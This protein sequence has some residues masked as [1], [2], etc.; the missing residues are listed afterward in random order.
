VKKKLIRKY[1]AWTLSHKKSLLFFF[2][3]FF[4]FF[5]YNLRSISINTD[6]SSLLPNKFSSVSRVKKLSKQIGNKNGSLIVGL[7]SDLPEKNIFLIE[8]IVSN[9]KSE[10]NIGVESYEYKYDKE[11]DFFYK[12][13][14]HL[15]KNKDILDLVNNIDKSIIDKKDKAFAGFLGL[16]EESDETNSAVEVEINDIIGNNFSKKYKKIFE[17]YKGYLSAEKGKVLALVLRPKNSSLALGAS[18]KLLT[19]VKAVVDRTIIEEKLQNKVEYVFMGSVQRSVFEYKNVIQD[20]YKTSLL[21][22]LLISLLM[23]IF[24]RSFKVMMCMLVSIVFGATAALVCLNLYVGYL[25]SYTAFL[26][27]IVIGTGV[28]YVIIFFFKIRELIKSQ[29]TYFDA[30]ENALSET[31]EQTFIACITTVIGFALLVLS[32]NNGL[33]HFAVLGSLGVLFCWLSSFSLF[34]LC[35]SY[36][37]QN[38]IKKKTTTI[39]FKPVLNFILKKARTLPLALLFMFFLFLSPLKNVLQDPFEFDFSKIGNK[40]INDEKSLALHK[41]VNKIFTVDKYPTLFFMENGRVSE[42]FCDEVMKIKVSGQASIDSCLSAHSFLPS[43]DN[44][45]PTAGRLDNLKFLKKKINNKLLRSADGKL[46]FSTW[47]EK[48]QLKPPEM[49]DLPKKI[50]RNFSDKSGEEARIAFVFPRS[51]HLTK[52]H[53]LSDYVASLETVNTVAGKAFGVGNS[54][55]INDLQGT[56]LKDA[57]KISIV[58]LLFIALMVLLITRKIYLSLFLLGTLLMSTFGLVGLMGF[59]GYKINFFNYIAF[60]IV[61]GVSVDYPAN[62]LL[63]MLKKGEFDSSV[64]NAVLLCSLTTMISYLCLFGANNQAIASFAKI[65]FLG[66]VLG[67][68]LAVLVGSWLLKFYYKV[69]I[70]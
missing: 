56:L 31:L 7:V 26:G 61:F 27:T 38:S 4:I 17:Y 67:L 19:N 16:E 29:Q 59:L 3:V 42:S 30:A 9:L 35:L 58:T 24:V 47:G 46:S 14:A 36:V 23:Y 64:L 32:D 37:N 20:L 15:L 60:P 44:S 51:A 2:A 33:T 45:N 63:G 57:S 43:S 11:K 66:E 53:L 39:N 8:R 62:V 5:L 41:R 49:S 68:F 48:F 70:V 65:S 34:I 50:L 1:L 21:L 13:G 25:N 18:Q 12:Y 52:A 28:N 55:I 54:F 40:T 6:I 10:R 22:L 69:K